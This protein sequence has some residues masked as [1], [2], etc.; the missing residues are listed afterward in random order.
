MPQ[1]KILIAEVT[2]LPGMAERVRDLLRNYGDVVRQ[3]P[4]NRTFTVYQVEN[5]PERFLVFEIYNDDAAFKAHLSAPENAE[6]N[7]KLGQLIEGGGS[8]LTFLMPVT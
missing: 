5:R 6:V 8:G 4:G 1:A 2:A 7:R 3:E